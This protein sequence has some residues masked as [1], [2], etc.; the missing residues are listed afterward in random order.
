[1]D[2]QRLVGYGDTG[3]L[4]LFYDQLFGN[5][6]LKLLNFIIIIMHPK[7]GHDP[8]FWTFDPLLCSAHTDVT[9]EIGEYFLLD[10]SA[11]RLQN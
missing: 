8:E 11:L 6:T 1:M 3:N 4:K 7:L 2:L 5:D 10:A 9:T